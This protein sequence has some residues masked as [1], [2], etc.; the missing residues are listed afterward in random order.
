[1]GYLYRP[2]AREPSPLVWLE[3]SLSEVQWGLVMSQMG[4]LVAMT[5]VVVITILLNASGIELSSEKDADLN[6]ELSSAGVAN[7]V[8]GCLGGIIGY[9]S[10]SR[11][12]LNFRAGG[13]IRPSGMAAAGFCVLFFLGASPLL[14]AI[15]KLVLGGL[16]LYLG[17][18]LL[19]EWVIQGW[20][21]LSRSDYA[22]V[23]AIMLVVATMGF[24]EGVLFGLVISVILVV[25]S[26]SS[27]NVVK[28]TTTGESHRSSFVRS[29]VQ[30]NMLK[31]EGGKVL[32]MN[33]HGYLFFG[34][35]HSLQEQVKEKLE[36][37][38][39]RIELVI[40]DFRLV[41]GL[42]SSVA[43]SFRKMLQVAIKNETQ[44]FLTD[45]TLQMEST[46][47]DLNL[48]G[49]HEDAFKSSRTLD[50]CVQRCE[51]QL[52]SSRGVDLKSTHRDISD[53]L[54]EM[55][56]PDYY[57]EG[58]VS[59]LKR[60]EYKK[61]DVIVQQGDIGESMYIVAMGQVTAQ[62]ELAGG[63]K[64]RLIAM[65]SATIFGEMGLYTTAPR[66]ASV[67]ADEDTVCY[68]LKNDDLEVMQ[69]EDP[70]M[71]TALHRYIISLLSG[72]IFLTN[73]KVRQLS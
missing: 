26:Y 42:D 43:L 20:T 28:L 11:S 6:R 56:L 9:Q 14:T 49:D 22:M 53:I 21:S 67:L 4:N 44:I 65:G 12:L 73:R 68:E 31:E 19:K 2:F 38:G 10:I 5:G 33:L 40:L 3:F 25:M 27:I 37:E 54:Q 23:M 36:E 7:M 29:M 55:F 47:K 1:M 63:H 52:L 51:D 32:I 15:P 58:F 66:S 18:G 34:T 24:L 41:T 45:L 13:T 59:Y 50:L 70:E 30:E 35:S 69:K 60:T 8:A 39:S 17:L 72:R 16:L 61:G 57:T 71:A 62:L 64:I 48:L 46:L